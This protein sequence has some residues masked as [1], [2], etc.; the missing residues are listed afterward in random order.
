MKRK[1]AFTV[2][3]TLTAGSSAV[4]VGGVSIAAFLGFSSAYSLANSRHYASKEIYKLSVMLRKDIEQAESFQV[5][6]SSNL[7][8]DV[9]D[10]AS[11]AISVTEYKL[12]TGN[13]VKVERLVGGSVDPQLNTVIQSVTFTK[14]NDGCLSYQLNFLAS[15]SQPATSYKGEVRLRNWI[16]K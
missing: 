4:I 16:K 8:L 7:K 6:N 3:E 13:P 11:G 5:T 14:V 2:A 10:P 15:P 9:K 12:T 1:R